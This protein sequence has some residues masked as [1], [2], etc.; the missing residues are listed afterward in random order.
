VVTGTQ[1][2]LDVTTASA[3]PEPS[4]MALLG[5]GL[6]GLGSTVRRKAT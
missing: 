1:I 4:A 2:I 5:V 6:L 3:I